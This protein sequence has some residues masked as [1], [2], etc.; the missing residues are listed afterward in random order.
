MTERRQDVGIDLASKNHLRH[1]QR[2]IVGYP[3]AFDDGLL[4]AQELGQVAQLLAAAMHHAEPDSDLMH[5]S[6]FFSQRDQPLG[7]FRDLAGEFHDER[8]SFEALN[9][10]QSLAE[11]IESQLIAD[12]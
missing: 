1:F 5:Q 2:G 10:R 11:E 9:V 6:E 12:F 3:A 8:F 7:S 4:D